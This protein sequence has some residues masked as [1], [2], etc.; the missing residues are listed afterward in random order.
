VLEA[1]VAVRS[2]G[3][4]QAVQRRKAI[5]CCCSTVGTEPCS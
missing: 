3:G 4:T 5:A 2:L 1:Q